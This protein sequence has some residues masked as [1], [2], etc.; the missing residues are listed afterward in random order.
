[1]KIKLFIPLLLYFLLTGSLKSATSKFILNEDE[2]DRSLTHFEQ[3]TN[4]PSDQLFNT[5]FLKAKDGEIQTRGGFLVR[6]FFCGCIALHRSYMGTNGETMWWFYCCVPGIG[7]INRTVD[8]WWVVFDDAAF[9]KYRNN[10][11]YLVWADNM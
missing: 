8:F 3:T 1:M 2:L 10:S 4:L 5:A 9:E 11:K 6:A 7:A